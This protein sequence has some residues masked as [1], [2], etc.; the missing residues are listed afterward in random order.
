M[1]EEWSARSTERVDAWFETAAL[2]LW[3][4]RRLLTTNGFLCSWFDGLSTNGIEEATS[5]RVVQG[6]GRTAWFETAALDLRSRRRLL[7]TND[8]LCS[9]F[10]GLS[11][12]G[13][14]GLT[15]NGIDGLTTNGIDGLIMN[16][17]GAMLI[18]WLPFVVSLSNHERNEAQPSPLPD[19]L[20][21]TP[22]GVGNKQNADSRFP[23][24]SPRFSPAKPTIRHPS[25]R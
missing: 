12:N 23:F 15:T 18:K 11:T 20:S 14:D 1:G 9:W 8:F 24:P 13:I 25:L 2:D 3:S 22:A 7:T 6:E 5:A 16:G 21:G 10:D 17:F 4:R 19:A